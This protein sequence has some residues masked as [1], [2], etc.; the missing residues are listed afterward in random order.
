VSVLITGATGYL[1]GLLA[2]GLGPDG[3]SGHRG[4]TVR[5]LGRADA[6]LGRPGALDHI[7]P[8]GITHI[9]HAA[10][11]TDFGVDRETA[12]AVNVEGTAR[13]IEF[14]QR[15]TGLRRYAQLS[16]LYSVGTRTGTV[17]EQLYE[18]GDFAN[19]YEWS[20]HAAESLVAGS[21]LPAVIVRV[22]TIAADDDG[23]HVTQYNAV[24]NTLKLVYYGLLSL[25]PGDPATPVPLTTAD[26]VLAVIE[27]AL[28]PGPAGVYHAAPA[29]VATLG[30]LIDICYDVFAEDPSFARRRILKPVFCDQESF[31][32]LVDAARS[33]RAG[34]VHDALASVAPFARQLYRPKRFASRDAGPLDPRELVRAVAKYLVA[35]RWGRDA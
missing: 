24:H 15:C 7:D 13:V 4:M 28:A 32:D 17:G 21:G 27:A 5:A 12:R 9:V 33:M 6:D 35:S 1:G 29:D 19:D 2:A 10:A 34:P 11:V 20:K 8:G 16:T 30:E 3:R 26:R 23:G 25:I 14:A 31:D 22:A 18:A